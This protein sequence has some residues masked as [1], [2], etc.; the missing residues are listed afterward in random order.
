MV[1]HQSKEHWYSDEKDYQKINEE[2]ELKRI[3]MLKKIE[4]D[5]D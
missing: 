3:K 5:F 1:R 4:S 2:K